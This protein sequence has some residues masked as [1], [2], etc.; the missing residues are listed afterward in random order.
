MALLG[1]AKRE[2]LGSFLKLER[3]IT[4]HDTFS[5]VLRLLD[6]EAFHSWFLVSMNRFA[7]KCQGVVAVGGKALRRSYDLAEGSSPLHLVSVWAA[8][9]CPSTSSGGPGATGD[10]R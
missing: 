1:Q 4:S 3:G 2:F 7:E 10:G 6:P 8:E 5:R 9:Q